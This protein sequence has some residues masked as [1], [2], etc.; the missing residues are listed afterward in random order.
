MAEKSFDPSCFAMQLPIPCEPD[1]SSGLTSNLQP[2][3]SQMNAEAVSSTR[4]NGTAFPGK[5]AEMSASVPTWERTREP[6][7]KWGS[8]QGRERASAGLVAKTAVTMDRWNLSPE[9]KPREVAQNTRLG[10]IPPKEQESWR[11]C[12]SHEWGLAPGAGGL[13]H[14][15]CLQASGTV[16]YH[17]HFIHATPADS[18]DVKSPSLLE[19]IIFSNYYEI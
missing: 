7:R 18:F 1:V 3:T 4:L 15:V 12:K 2:P 5:P 13:A 17:L 16:S 19:V 11:V 14:W 9:G 6:S 10:I 8:L